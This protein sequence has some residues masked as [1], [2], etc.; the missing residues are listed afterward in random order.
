MPYT[1]NLTVGYSKSSHNI[2]IS[3]ET[4]DNTT[5]SIGWNFDNGRITLAK[6][7]DRKNLAIP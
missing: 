7:D 1:S 6:G 4:A 2:W 5:E 3:V